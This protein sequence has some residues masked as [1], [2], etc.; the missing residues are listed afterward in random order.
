MHTGPPYAVGRDRVHHGARVRPD[1]YV[2]PSERVAGAVGGTTAL[3]LLCVFTVVNIAVLV[4]RRDTI[5]HKH[6][7]APTVLPIIG[8]AVCFFLPCRSTGRDPVQYT[9]AAWLLAI[10]VVLWA[11]TWLANRSSSARDLLGN[12]EEREPV[13]PLKGRRAPDYCRSPRAPAA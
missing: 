5:D 12:P 4:L 7:V 6:F 9:I 11:L 8:A 13:T 1:L 3:L 10:G 2:S